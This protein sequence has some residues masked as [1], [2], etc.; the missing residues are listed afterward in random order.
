MRGRV[1]GWLLGRDVSVNVI[2][3]QVPVQFQENLLLPLNLP[4]TQRLDG[5]VGRLAVSEGYFRL[6]ARSRPR[7]A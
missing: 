7:V 6:P 5:V 4:A 3:A 1:N 2:G